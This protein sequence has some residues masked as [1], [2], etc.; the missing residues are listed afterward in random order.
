[1]AGCTKIFMFIFIINSVFVNAQSSIS[2]PHG[3]QLDIACEVCH[4]TS[5]WRDVPR[6]KFN[7]DQVGFSIDG[8]H[9]YVECIDCHNTL[10][11]NDVGTACAD[12]HTDFHKAELGNQCE[13]CH[14]AHSWENRDQVFKEHNK[15][16]FPLVGVHAN[17]DCESCHIAEQ[18]RQYANLSIECQSCHLDDYMNTLSPEHQ[19]AGFN[20]DCNNCHQPSA[21]TWKADTYVHSILFP[22]TGGHG[23]LDCEACHLNN[24]LESIPKECVSCHR[25]D[26]DNVVYPDHVENNF[27]FD[28][29]ICHNINAWSPAD[30]DHNKTEFPLTGAHIS[31]DCTLCHTNGFENAPTDCFACHDLDYNNTTDPNHNAANFPN[32]CEDCHST[33]AWVPASWDHDEQFFPIFSGKHREEWDLCSD[34]HVDAN[35]FKQ[36]ECINCHEHRQSEMDDKHKEEKDYVWESQACYT[37]HP[38]GSD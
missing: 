27:D 29:T 25:Q 6:H 21:T 5:D 7:H 30:F 13:S 3:D 8:E 28:C 22:L 4:I 2:N 12:C 24:K 17:L 1:M 16:N 38:N 33:S 20:L 36:F 34:C 9:K 37:C 10:V 15:T 19:K 18:Q 35:D 32:S 11:F 23:N 31:I 14:T 26:Y